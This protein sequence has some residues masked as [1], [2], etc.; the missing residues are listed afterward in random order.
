MHDRGS[1]HIDG[2]GRT[3]SVSQPGVASGTL[4]YRGG[5]SR[6]TQRIVIAVVALALIASMGAVG[7]S[8]MFSAD[9]G[10]TA[11]EQ[12]GS[13]L[14]DTRP[15][16]DPA[17]QP[18]PSPTTA[19]EPP[20]AMHEQSSEGAQASLGYMLDSY[21][22][23]MATGDTSAWSSGINPTCQV[24]VQF[25]ANAKAL[26]TQGG[27]S[28]GGEFT[29]TATSFQ[30]VGDPPAS[31]VATADF[32]QAPQRI[33]DDPSRESATMPEVTAQIQARMA[34][35]GEQWRVGDMTIVQPGTGPSDGGG[36][37]DAG[38]GSAV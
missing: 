10:T 27:W 29:V 19:P 31:G 21:A 12:N 13:S 6:R 11:A 14:G 23:M 28:A 18:K 4:G 33:V 36:G 5:V 17:T 34:W 30:G 15:V 37:S 26:H 38:G 20:V 32:H 9:P 7:L 8:S 22:Y 35:D 3:T 24:C 16:V 2:V 1:E 25:V